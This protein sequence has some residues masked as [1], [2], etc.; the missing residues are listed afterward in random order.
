MKTTRIEDNQLEDDHIVAKEEYTYK[1]DDRQDDRLGQ[2]FAIG[3]ECGKE[4]GNDSCS[5]SQANS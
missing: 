3:T 1:K 2:K 4:I 5:Q